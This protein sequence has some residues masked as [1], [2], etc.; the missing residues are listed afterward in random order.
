[1]FK[2]SKKF[3]IIDFIIPL[4]TI[5][6]IIIL[7]FAI[8]N[9]IK[10]RGQIKVYNNL[11][12]QIKKS[13]QTYAQETELIYPKIITVNKLIVD[14]YLEIEN[15]ELADPLNKNQILN[16][17]TIYIEKINN[18]YSVKYNN[19]KDCELVENEKIDAHLYAKT[20]EGS[21]E[22]VISGQ[23]TTQDL[24][25][26]LEINT[27]VTSITWYESGQIIPNLV[28]NQKSLEIRTLDNHVGDYIVEIKTPKGNKK[29]SFQINIDKSLPA[30]VD[31]ETRQVSE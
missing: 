15:Q 25:L 22:F 8:V 1:M 18:E 10:R 12:D 31:T 9:T 24:L 23:K 28:E 7:T 19:V 13:A 30:D 2:N 4:I 17:Q 11:I 3:T 20:L 29:I 14:G 5:I 21:D 16:C 26:F 6:I 27:E